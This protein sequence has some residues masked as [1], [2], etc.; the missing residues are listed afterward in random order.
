[1]LRRIT[2]TI[3]IAL[4]LLLALASVASAR[5]AIRGPAYRTYAPSGWHIDKRTSGGWNT[6]TIT[7]PSHVSNGRDTALVSIAVAPVSRVKR[8]SGGIKVSDKAKL[9]QQLI[10][11]PSDASNFKVAGQPRPV[12]FRGK[13]AE[14]Y[15]VNYTYTGHGTTHTATLVRRGKRIYLIQVITDQDVAFLGSSAADSIRASWR[16]K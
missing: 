8:L 13:P 16:W 12:R 4:L 7:P 6:V 9:I 15:A 3:L 5:E 2:P 10:S 14:F 1:M 11:V